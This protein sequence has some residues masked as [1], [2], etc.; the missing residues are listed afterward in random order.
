MGCKASSRAR[1]PRTSPF[2]ATPLFAHQPPGD[3]SADGRRPHSRP[4]G[5]RRGVELLIVAFDPGRDANCDDR[6]GSAGDQEDRPG[7]PGMRAGPPGGGRCPCRCGC[8]LS[9]FLSLR[10]SLSLSVPPPRPSV[11]A[12]PRP[13]PPSPPQDPPQ[14][15]RSHSSFAPTAARASASPPARR[16]PATK[17]PARLRRRHPPHR[18]LVRCTRGFGRRRAFGRGGLGRP[19]RDSR[20]IRGP[21]ERRPS[22]E[23]HPARGGTPSPARGQGGRALALGT[24]ADTGAGTD[25]CADTGAASIIANHTAPKLSPP[26]FIRR[27]FAPGS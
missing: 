23:H 2:F 12:S 24:G 22:R 1:A 21:V 20:G 10:L 16:S 9:L 15:S 8:S 4:D 3:A 6:A 25:S 14:P 13:A 5:H 19:G 11:P 18:G 7:L 27:P 26:A 17:S